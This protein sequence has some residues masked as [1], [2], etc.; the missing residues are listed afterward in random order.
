M[1]LQHMLFI[2]LAFPDDPRSARYVAEGKKL[3]TW[4]L[5]GGPNNGGWNEKRQEF[6]RLPDQ[7]QHDR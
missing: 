7:G 6:E 3:L 1:P 5:E 4:V 2:G